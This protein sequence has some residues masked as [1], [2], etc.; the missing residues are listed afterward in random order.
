M[1]KNRSTSFPMEL[2]ISCVC[3]CL[4]HVPFSIFCFMWKLLSRYCINNTQLFG[5]NITICVCSQFVYES[6]MKHSSE[7]FVPRLFH[8]NKISNQMCD[9]FH[10]GFVYQFFVSMAEIWSESVSS[11]ANVC[12]MNR[13]QPA[14]HLCRR[15]SSEFDQRATW[16][17]S[18]KVWEP[19]K[20]IE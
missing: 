11:N 7:W 5:D 9:T 1:S 13:A 10:S 14:Q 6:F 4:L 18:N 8:A 16:P 20:T 19:E 12:K 15:I 2:F 3:V 17:Y